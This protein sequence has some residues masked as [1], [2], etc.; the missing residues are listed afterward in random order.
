MAHMAYG[1]LQA[2]LSLRS[3]TR[4]P[5][6]VS[7]VPNRNIN[8]RFDGFFNYS[9]RPTRIDF[10]L[11]IVSGSQD[12]V[13]SETVIFP[14]SNEWFGTPGNYMYTMLG[15]QTLSFSRSDFPSGVSTASARI[16]AKPNFGPS[17]GRWVEGYRFAVGIDFVNPDARF[18]VSRSSIVKGGSITVN[19][20]S[21][22]TENGLS[23]TTYAWTFQGGSPGSST[24]KSPGAI[25][26]NTAGNYTI[27]LRVNKPGATADTYTRNITVTE[28]LPVAGFNASSTNIKEGE[29]VTFTNTST[30]TKS[31]STYSWSFQ[32]GSPASSTAKAP[33]AVTFSNHGT[34]TVSLRVTNPGAGSNTATKT[35]TVTQEIPPIPSNFSRRLIG[36]SYRPGLNFSWTP[37]GS[38]IADGYRIYVNFPGSRYYDL[39]AEIPGGDVGS[40]TDWNICDNSYCSPRGYGYVIRAYNSGGQL[41]PPSFYG[42]MSAEE[43][44]AEGM[45]LAEQYA[46]PNPVQ[47]QL[48]IRRPNEGQRTVNSFVVA[49]NAQGQMVWSEHMPV[50][51]E[52]M[53]IDVSNWPTGQYLFVVDGKSHRI[54]VN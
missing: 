7:E 17:A 8:I 40:Y 13:A 46:Y 20:T 54:I 11:R 38:Q 47:S 53:A 30:R 1:Q 41:P 6:E 51:Q 34:Y 16:E 33:P 37:L 19:N 48:F 39:Y 12:K 23:P 14:S 32:G 27:T 43:M 35:I 18:T 44:A 21:T 2:T 28:D 25:T 50:A 24:A 10:R 4:F 22:N 29:S 31:N 42:R 52:V 36:P 9:S 3:H 45:Q 49:Y 5:V 26:Y 15:Q